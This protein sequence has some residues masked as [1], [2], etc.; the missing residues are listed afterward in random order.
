[1][2]NLYHIVRYGSGWALAA[3]LWM[4]V[5]S[6]VGLHDRY[7]HYHGYLTYFFAIPWVFIYYRGIRQRAVTA[8][9]LEFREAFLLGCGITLAA[10]VLT[11]VVWWAFAGWLNPDFL[12]AK[13]Q[14]AIGHGMDPEAAA[15]RY[16]LVN[17]LVISAFSTAVIGSVI[18]LVIAIIFARRVFIS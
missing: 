13:A 6:W 9:R 2:D 3:L 17:H 1:M 16:S 5:E 18:S 7:M 4:L 12:T 11:P 15:L 14:H 10:T 8:G